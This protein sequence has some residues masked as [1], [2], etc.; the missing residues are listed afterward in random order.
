MQEE[1]ITS[2]FAY[3]SATLRNSGSVLMAMSVGSIIN[4]PVSTS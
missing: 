1:K 3:S 4:S 2:S